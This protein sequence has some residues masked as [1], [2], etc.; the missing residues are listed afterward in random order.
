[1]HQVEKMQRVVWMLSFE[2]GGG[3]DRRGEEDGTLSPVKLRNIP[4]EILQP[5]HRKFG[6][7]PRHHPGGATVTLQNN[8]DR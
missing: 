6:H 4:R 2:D 7:H 1:M 5:V 3:E 8:E